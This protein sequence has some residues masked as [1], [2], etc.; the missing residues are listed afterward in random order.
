VSLSRIVLLALV[1]SAVSCGSSR[2]EPLA[3]SE[4]ALTS[5]RPQFLTLPHHPHEED[6]SGEGLIEFDHR[7]IWNAPLENGLPPPMNTAA[8]GPGPQSP[9]AARAGGTGGGGSTAAVNASNAPDSYQGETAAAFNG[10]VL[11]GGSNSIYPGACSTSP[12]YVRAYTTANGV[13]YV[14][15]TLPGT[16]NGRTFGITFDPSLDHDKAGNFYYAFGGAP[17]SGSYPNS[18]GVSKAG[19][20]G[21]GWGTP[22]AVTFN[23]NRFFDDKYYLAI[24][25]SSSAFANRIYVSWDRNSGNNQIL[26]IS[27]SSDGGNTWSAPV[28]VNDGTSKFERVIGAYPAVDHNTGTVYDSWHDYAKDI[29]FVDRSTNGGASWGTDVAAATTHTGFGVDIGCVGGRS[30]S[31]AHHLKVGPSG[32]LHLVYA[33]SVQGRGFDVLYTRSTNGGQT[34]SAPVRLDDDGGA[35]DQFHPTLSVTSNG[36]GGDRV[37]VTF[38]DR[39]E[40]AAN[41]LSHV[42]S[43]VSTDS[44]LTWSANVKQTTTPSNFDGNPNGPGDYSSA[45][46]SFAGATAF[47]SQHTTADFDVYAFPF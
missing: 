47:H 27:Y 10:S 11:V 26:Y 13:S 15:S 31:P 18:I 28:K 42:Y 2:T 34:W 39:R 1:A 44:G 45:S 25:R 43:T 20:S 40:D 4:A 41:C 17:L 21:T 16:W 3:T 6:E 24:D 9:L 46:P 14:S 33:D 7:Y 37:A 36:A 38:Y 30:Q 35:A 12:C 32:T 19:P 5:V 22:V 8:P 23:R 29:I